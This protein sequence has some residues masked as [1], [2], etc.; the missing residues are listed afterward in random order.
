MGHDPDKE[1]SEPTFDDDVRIAYAAIGEGDITHAIHHVAGAVAAGADRDECR[2]LIDVFA[3]ATA[4]DPLM[5]V[6]S[7][8]LW[9][10]LGALRAE[11]LVRAGRKRE[12]VPLL[13]AC[14]SAV[15]GAPFVPW[16]DRWCDAETCAAI[17]PDDVA[18]ELTRCTKHEPLGAA[19]YAIAR[20]LHDAHPSHDLMAFA[21]VKLARMC[22]RMDD[23][24]ELARSALARGPM[25]MTAIALAGTYREM[26][27][28]PA[29][30]AAFE[31]AQK[32]DPSNAG[33]MLDLGD[34]A[35]QL[36]DLAKSLHWYEEAISVE[37]DNDWAMASALFVRWKESGD[38][39]HA[40]EL[41]AY[42]EEHP[43]SN[44]ARNLLAEVDA[45]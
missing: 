28:L 42:A 31:D 40:E 19:L 21:A 26:G 14:L 45:D 25:P 10:G 11:L 44:R 17:V 34:I 22:W 29:C 9:Y 37:P 18:R 6:P 33:I 35:L 12:A 30:F 39:E 4:P 38:E 16:L 27:D 8:D 32:L 3:A 2:E 36:G 13:L 24:V 7:K 43:D 15:P 23:A 5:H 1:P 41:R 20:R